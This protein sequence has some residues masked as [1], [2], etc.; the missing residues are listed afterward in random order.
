M[1]ISDQLMNGFTREKAMGDYLEGAQWAEQGWRRKVSGVEHG[2]WQGGGEGG[3]TKGDAVE[4]GLYA[5]I[6]IEKATFSQTPEGLLWCVK[7]FGPSN[8][9]K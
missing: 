2:E 6:W 7:E 3:G 4:M 8:I 9:C 1:T 5:G